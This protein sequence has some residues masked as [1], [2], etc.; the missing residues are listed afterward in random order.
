MKNFRNN[1]TS[2]VTDEAKKKFKEQWDNTK[3][4]EEEDN[5]RREN[6]LKIVEPMIPKEPM[7]AVM[8][9]PEVITLVGE[10]RICWGCLSL[11]CRIRQMLSQ[12]ILGK[13]LVNRF[14]P[15]Q[16]VLLGD[17]NLVRNLKGKVGKNNFV[18]TQFDPATKKT[19]VPNKFQRGPRPNRPTFSH[20]T[21]SIIPKEASPEPAEKIVRANFTG[22]TDDDLFGPAFLYEEPELFV[23]KKVVPIKT[24]HKRYEYP[25][26]E[27]YYQEDYEKEPVFCFECDNQLGYGEICL[28]CEVPTETEEKTEEVK[29]EN[30]EER[31]PIY[32]T[33]DKIRLEKR[34][35]ETSKGL[36]SMQE[37]TT[38]TK[39]DIE[40]MAN[41]FNKL[42]NRVSGIQSYIHGDLTD[43]RQEMYFWSSSFIV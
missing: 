43:F 34:L 32:D 21:A 12:R 27:E 8:D 37:W 17:R 40:N 6:I 28:D 10:A 13:K 42:D 36:R 20:N 38:E 31:S 19:F 30:K 39:E 15:V 29:W 3:V 7:K 1:T 14:C 35:E 9:I 5:T 22:L 25:P 26:Q 2:V 4:N 41:C 24:N 33:E 16:K 23:E 18:T 11:I